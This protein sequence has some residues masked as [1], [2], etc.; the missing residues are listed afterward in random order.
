MPVVAEDDCTRAVKVAATRIAS[1]GRSISAIRS[2]KGSEVRKGA[3]ASLMMPIPKNTSPSPMII[4][5]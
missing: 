1:M 4:A 2:R 5:P 3:I